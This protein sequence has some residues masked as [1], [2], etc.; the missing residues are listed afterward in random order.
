MATLVN[1]TFKSVQLQ[2]FV[3]LQCNEHLVDDKLRNLGSLGPFTKNF[4]K[5]P[6]EGPSSEER[7]PF[8]ESSIRLCSR[9]QI[10]DG[11]TDIAA[12]FP[13]NGDYM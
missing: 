7:V 11:G 1:Y 8:D 12:E 6:W 10:L 4:R 2:I 5:L 9:Q 3:P 13:G